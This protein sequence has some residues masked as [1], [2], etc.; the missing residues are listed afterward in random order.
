MRKPLLFLHLLIMILLLLLGSVTTYA[1]GSIKVLGPLVNERVATIGAS[2]DGSILIENTGKTPCQVRIYQTDY[3]YYADGRS[4][5]GV[6]GENPASN[7]NWITLGANWVTVPAQVKA[8]V[9]Y[10]VQVPPNPGLQGS[11][12]SMLMVEAEDDQPVNSREKG[13]G[14]IALRTKIRYGVQVITNIG[15]TGTRRIQFLDRKIINQ[16]GR[17]ILQLDIE[18]SG[19]RTLTPTVSLQ[20]FNN[21]GKLISNY[22]GDEFR[23]LPTC[24]I[25]QRIDL[26]DFPKGT[27][28]ALVIV[29]NGDQ[30]V[31][32][33][34]YNLVIG[35]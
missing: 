3:L 22:Q 11:Y 4:I 12:W 33:A 15:N 6:L 31:F 8:A 23:I 21:D 25:R 10:K 34:N 1:A 29:D 30:Y 2:Y 19:E 16:D 9:N 32:G 17:R 18:N 7:G 13:K 24:S 5:Y 27:Y 26:P 35:K 28:K 20:L 14:A